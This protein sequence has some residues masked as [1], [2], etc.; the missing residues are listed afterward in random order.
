MYPLLGFSRFVFCFKAEDGIRD[1]AVTGVQTC[2]LPISACSRRVLMAEIRYAPTDGLTSNPND[3]KYWDRSAL[4][5]EI[6]RTFDL[7]NGCRMCFKYCQAFPTLFDA[8]E[9]AGAGRG[10]PQAT[11]GCGLDGL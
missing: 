6:H 9:Q 2:A 10:R 5:K 3:P 4:D 8:V 1:V 7:C 11:V